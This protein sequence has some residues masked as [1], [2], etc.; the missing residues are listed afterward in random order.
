MKKANKQPPRLTILQKTRLARLEPDL[1]HCVL[2][3]DFEQAKRNIAK[4]QNLL[5]RTGH[6]TRL[7]QDK[8]WFYEAALE[9]GKVN[10]AISGF[11]GTRNIASKR[12]RLYLEAS[13]LLA[14]CYLRKG[15][16]K[17]AKIYISE[18]IGCINNIRSS[19]RR[20]QF[21]SVFITRIHDETLLLGLKNKGH[22][23]LKIDNIH[24]QAIHLLTTKTED[25][26]LDSMVDML[27]GESISLLK[28]VDSSSR[29]LIFEPDRKYLPAPVND[30][31]RR[32]LRDKVN[33]A[34]KR[35]VWKALCSPDSELYKAWSKSLAVVHDEK[36]IAA[37]VVTSFRSW[38]IG[39]GMLAAS[40][41]ALAVRFG[42]D[43][44]CEYFKPESLMIDRRKV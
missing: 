20:R 40:V 12:T 41:T 23:A 30:K 11:E 14:V 42:V 32:E 28:S 33:S 5:R 16:V 27:P 39:I 6:I 7:L 22:S 1:R 3:G 35:V 34:L 36:W 29:K 44:F 43:F 10:F 31:K 38:H 2:V 4:I 17:Q 9:A 8:N 21:H 13:A 26:I 25:E 24:K 19:R 15:D 37:A 18:A